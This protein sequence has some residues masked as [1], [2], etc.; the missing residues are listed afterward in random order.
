MVG[1]TIDRHGDEEGARGKGVTADM[2]VSAALRYLQQHGETSTVVTE[3][4]LP[5][6]VV[7]LQALEGSPGAVPGPNAGVADVMDWECVH[8]APDADPLATLRAYQDG[9]W[10]SLRRRRPM[11]TDV[12]RRRTAL[13][14]P[15]APVR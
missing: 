14:R 5:V 1:T 11:A 10:R 6:G 4:G 2:T 8:V 3:N 13:F 15:R 12:R 7:T 9:S